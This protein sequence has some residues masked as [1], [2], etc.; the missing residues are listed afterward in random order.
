MCL[1]GHF[2]KSINIPPSQQ[3]LLKC[4]HT[5]THTHT[6]THTQALQY[7][8]N[9]ELQVFGGSGDELRVFKGVVLCYVVLTIPV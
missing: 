6:N 7:I 3:E 5:R 4:L 2:W 9:L 1:T 8:T